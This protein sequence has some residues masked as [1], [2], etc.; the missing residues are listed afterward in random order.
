MKLALLLASVAA[1]ANEV[2]Y[3]WPERVPGEETIKNERIASVPNPNLTVYL[4]DPSKAT[5]VAIVAS[6]ARAGSA[7]WFAQRCRATRLPAS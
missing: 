3:L 1:F 6:A 7:Q 5:G 4:P 2:V